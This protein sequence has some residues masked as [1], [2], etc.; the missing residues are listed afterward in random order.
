MLSLLRRKSSVA[1]V[2]ETNLLKHHASRLASQDGRSANGKS[3]AVNAEEHR[4]E[5]SSNVMDL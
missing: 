5:R 3:N 1:V 4:L 2:P